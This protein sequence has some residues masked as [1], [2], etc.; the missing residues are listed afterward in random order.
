MAFDLGEPK[1]DANYVYKYT[2]NFNVIGS[3]FGID[4]KVTDFVTENSS[5]IGSK[6]MNTFQLSLVEFEWFDIEIGKCQTNHLEYDCIKTNWTHDRACTK[7]N[8]RSILAVQNQSN[9]QRWKTVFSIENESITSLV[10]F[11]SVQ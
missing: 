7:W 4:S 5:E 9:V 6:F 2:H 10:E 8:A 1:I 11:N 3:L